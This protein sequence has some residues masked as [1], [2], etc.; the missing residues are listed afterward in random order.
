MSKPTSKAIAEK[1]GCGQRHARRLIAADDW[2][3]YPDEPIKPKPASEDGILRWH[4]RQAD[5][6]FETLWQYLDGRT[7][8]YT[9]GE[10]LKK[11]LSAVTDAYNHALDVIYGSN[12]PS[13]RLSI[14]AGEPTM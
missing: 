12:R 3:I 7:P 14:L 9:D 2:R 11:R 6:H 8:L 5:S 13:R 1:L 10:E 4:A